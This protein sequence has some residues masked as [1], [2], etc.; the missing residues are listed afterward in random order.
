MYGKYR[1][2]LLSCHVRR[3]LIIEPYVDGYIL[4]EDYPTHISNIPD[5]GAR[6]SVAHA[7]TYFG[8]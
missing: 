1:G 6:S 5:H 7:F 2:I 4:H 3:Y 8:G